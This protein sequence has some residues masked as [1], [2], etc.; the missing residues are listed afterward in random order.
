MDMGAAVSIGLGTAYHLAGNGRDFSD[1]EDHEAN[2]V[3]GGIAFGPL[4]VHVRQTVGLIP[5]GQR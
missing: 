4:E 1:T 2:K 3:R 5:H